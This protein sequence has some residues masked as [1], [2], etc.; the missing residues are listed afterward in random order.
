MQALIAGGWNLEIRVGELALEQLAD[1]GRDRHIFLHGLHRKQP[2]GELR[3]HNRYVSL[4]RSGRSSCHGVTSSG[5][6]RRA[7]FLAR[8]SMKAWAS[9]CILLSPSTPPRRL[10]I[11]S[12]RLPVKPKAS[13][14]RR[15]AVGCLPLGI[16]SFPALQA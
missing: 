12:Q 4:L 10:M 14:S 11:L 1:K 8:P 13:A 2:V 7:V 6:T 3:E 16:T 9:G 15:P 5:S